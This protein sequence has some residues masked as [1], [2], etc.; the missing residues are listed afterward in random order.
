ME[1]KAEATARQT[2]L[3]AAADARQVE[4]TASAEAKRIEQVGVAEATATEATGRADGEAIRARGTAEADAI[5]RRAEALAAE[6][7]AVIAQQVAEQLPENV[8][9]AA[10]AF[11]NVDSMTVLNGAQG[12][13]EVMNQ[14]VAQAGPVL[15]L[16][17][18]TFRNRS[19]GNG[20]RP[21]SEVQAEGEDSR[22]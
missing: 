6:S 9:A 12:I 20:A 11:N 4:L 18:G 2:E 22:A 21:A 1:L 14:L 13:T 10:G 17:R 8:K 5:A 19:G 7:E 15:D 16:A 3:Q